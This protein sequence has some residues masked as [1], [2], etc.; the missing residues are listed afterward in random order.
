MFDRDK[1][2]EIGVVLGRNKL[3]TFLTAFGVF[4]GILMMV[5]MLGSGNGLMNGAQA[6]FG[7]TVTNSMFMWTQQTS[8]A[9]KG[10][11]R[12]RYFNM[13]NGDIEAVKNSVAG[14]DIISP[15]CQ[16]GGYRGSDNVTHGTKTGAFNIHGDYPQFLEIEP[17]DIVEG[18]FIN[19]IDIK[20]KRKVCFIGREVYNTL[21]EPGEDFLGSYIRAQGV[22][23]KVVGMYKSKVDDPNR[24][25]EQEKSIIIPL[26]TFQQAYNWGD[27]IG[28]V[29]ITAKPNVAVSQ[30]G[31]QIK[32]VIKERHSIHPD[33]ERAFG[34]WNKE[35]AFNR[36]IGLLTGINILSFVVGALTLFA[37][38]IGVSNIMLIT[39]KERTKEFGVRRAIGAPPITIITQ[40]M[41]ESV[42][43]TVVAGVLGVVAGVWLLEM[44]TVFMNSSAGA[45]G[46]MFRNPGVKLPIVLI[47]LMILVVC[48]LIAGII[49]ARRAVSIK[50]VDALRAE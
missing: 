15:R 2:H 40:V 47:S 36:M 46:G 29:A 9:Y 43:L 37:G 17:M 26:T 38:A 8:M 45:E 49:P 41:L 13:R 27:I 44:V 12:G 23:Y 31:E 35:E 24:A 22:N 39:V 28:W 3:R 32:Q 4:W 21:Y 10:F 33:D 25:E 48:G 18:R 14:L 30:V 7:G 19:E 1:W 16:A 50:P 6:G 42:T 5:I 11:K 34:S 20:E